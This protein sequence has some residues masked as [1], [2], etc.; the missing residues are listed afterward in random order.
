MYNV[1]CTMSFRVVNYLNNKKIHVDIMCIRAYTTNIIIDD[2]IYFTGLHGLQALTAVVYDD[3]SS[4][5]D[6]TVVC[7]KFTPCWPQ[8]VPMII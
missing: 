4:S 8:Q 3:G 1:R 2:P 5:P 7:T 6:P